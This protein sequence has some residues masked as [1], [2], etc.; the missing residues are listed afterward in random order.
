LDNNG[1]ATTKQFEERLDCSANMAIRTMTTLKI[2]GLID[3]SKDNP[4]EK[5]GRPMKIAVLKPKFQWVLK[6]EFKALLKE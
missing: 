4:G 3:I 1:T 2:L 5:G 6:Q